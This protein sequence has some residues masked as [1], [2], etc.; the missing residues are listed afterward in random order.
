MGTRY[1]LRWTPQAGAWLEGFDLGN[2]QVAATLTGTGQAAIDWLRGLQEEISGLNPEAARRRVV[3][4]AVWRQVVE[5]SGST[6]YGRNGAP[7][8]WSGLGE[9]AV[10]AHVHDWGDRARVANDP[11]APG[12]V[13][14]RLAR[15][16]HPK[17]RLQAEARLGRAI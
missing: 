5:P 2:E 8:G 14:E 15:D 16:E 3:N 9:L 6:D 12:W 10:A 11:R 4:A 7:F 17:V 13:L 1:Q